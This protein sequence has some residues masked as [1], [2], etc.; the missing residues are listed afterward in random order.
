[1]K[2]RLKHSLAA[3]QLLL[4]ASC[5]DFDGIRSPSR[6]IDVDEKSGSH[7]RFEGRWKATSQSG[8]AVIP[9]INTTSGSC[10]KETMSCTET[11]A[12]LFSTADKTPDG[13]SRLFLQNNYYRVI[14]PRKQFTQRRKRPW[15]TLSFASHWSI[16]PLREAH[17]RRKLGVQRRQTRISLGNGFLSEL[18]K[19]GVA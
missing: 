15:Q 13:I 16:V 10:A 8:L 12:L 3:I 11:I 18:L 14:G 1:M 4:L 19:T 9:K 2:E 7:V 6:R 17:G 5:S